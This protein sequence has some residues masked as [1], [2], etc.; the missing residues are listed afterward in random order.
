MLRHARQACGIK[1]QLVA[2]HDG[3]ASGQW[4]YNHL[5]ACLLV[6]DADM[7]SN[8]SAP[9]ASTPLNTI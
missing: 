9:W 3:H 8:C 1:Q 4:R 6:S 2:L 5:H 7:H